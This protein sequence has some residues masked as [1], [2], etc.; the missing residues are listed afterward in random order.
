M[1]VDVDNKL[2][3]E[4]TVTQRKVIEWDIATEFF[5]EDMKRRLQYTFM[6][7]YDQC[8]NRMIQEWMPV[9]R[10]RF[11]QLPTNYEALA[12]IIFQQP[13]YKDKSKKE[14]D[15]KDKDKP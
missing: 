1:K 5:E 2:L 3:F 12:N 13:D 15:K 4:I 7:K 14:K 6:H 10:E 8:L 9:L 11:A